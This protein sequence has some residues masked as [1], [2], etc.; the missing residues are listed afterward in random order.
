MG[1]RRRVK[2]G[3]ERVT[4]G[5]DAVECFI[6]IMFEGKGLF[7]CATEYIQLNVSSTFVSM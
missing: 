6:C 4:F 3:M 5:R 1:E 2:V 7:S